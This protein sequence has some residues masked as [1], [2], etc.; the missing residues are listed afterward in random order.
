MRTLTEIGS[1]LIIK[2]ESP[3]MINELKLNQLHGG[4]KNPLGQVRRLVQQHWK[5]IGWTKKASERL[6]TDLDSL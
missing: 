6:F 2:H 3:V 5:T 4:T 1:D